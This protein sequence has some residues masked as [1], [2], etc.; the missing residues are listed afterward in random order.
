[1]L[2]GISMNPSGETVSSVTYNGVNLTHVGTQ[3]DGAALARVEIW[4]LVA[5]DTGTHDVVVNFTDLGHKGASVGVMTFTGVNQTTPTQAF[6]G[7]SGLS[8]SASTTVASATDDLVF[9]V[10]AV[11]KGTA[12]TPGA[13]QTEYWDIDV[14]AT[15]GAGTTEAG[16]ASVTTS[17]T[18]DLK[19]WSAAAVSI[20]ADDGTATILDQFNTAGSFAGND[21]T[22]NWTGDWQELGESNGASSGNV[23]VVA[24][25]AALLIGSTGVITGDGALREVDLSQASTATLT[26]DA[27]RSASRAATITLAVS[28]NGGTSWTNLQTWSFSS[29]TSTP[30]LQTFDISAYTS[31]NTQIRFLGAGEADSANFYADNIQIEYTAMPLN[32]APV[33]TVPGTQVT[34]QDTP[35]VFNTTNG[36]A[37]SIA[38]DDAG[39]S[40]VE[41]TLTATD[42]TLSLYGSGGLVKVGNEVTTNTDSSYVQANSK[43]A[44]DASGAYVVVWESIGQD[45]DMEGIF[46]QRYDADGIAIGSAWQVNTEFTDDQSEPAIAMDAAGNFVITWQSYAQDK[47]NT[48][49]VYAQRYNAAGV[50]QGGEIQVNTTTNGN[51]QYPDIAMDSAGNFVIV[52]DGQGSGDGNGIF[53]QR[54]DAAGNTVGGEILINTETADTQWRATVDM[55]AAGEFIVTWGSNL[56]DGDGWGIYAQRYNSDGTT[57]GGEFLV[58]A[59]TAG[60][61][62]DPVV[63]LKDDGEFVVGWSMDDA[64]SRGINARVFDA[65]ATA[66]T[67]DI[68]VN[69][70]TAGMQYPFDLA[71]SD[72]GG[73]VATWTGPVQDIFMQKFDWSGAKVGAEVLVNTTTSGTQT[74]STVA[75]NVNGDYVVL[76]KHDFSVPNN[77]IYAQHYYNPDLT[78]TNGDGNSDSAMTLSGTLADINTVLE[79]LTFNPDSGFNGTATVTITTDDQGNTGSG[80]AFSDSDM[81]MITVGNANAPVVNLD[82]N[83]S[84]GA[85]GNHFSTG[86]T[87]G[88]GTVL[89]A[90]SDA[91]LIDTDENVTGM[92]VTITNQ[93]NGTDEVLAA[94][95]SGTSILASYDSGTGV[96]TLSGADTAAKYQQ[97]LRTISYNNTATTVNATSR[98]ISFV[99]TDA[100]SNGNTA[101]TTLAVTLQNTAPTFGVGDGAITTAIGA[102]VDF[103]NSMIVQ[104]DGKILVAGY[105]HNGTDYDFA[106]T[107]YNAD[108]SLD[109]SFGGGDG[110]VTTAVGAGFDQAHAITLQPDGKILVTGS[111]HNGSNTDVALL[112][113][114]ADGTLD[115][116]FGGGDGIVTTNFGFGTDAG[117][118]VAVQADGKILVTGN[119]WDGS[120]QEIAL[121]RYNTDGTLDTSFSGDGKLTISF[122]VNND[123]GA[124]VTVQPDGQILV[125]GQTF[126]GTDNDLVLLRYNTD[127]TLDTSFSGD[128]IVITDVAS[129]GDAG[130]QAVLQPDGKIL[131]GGQTGPG[132]AGVDILLV[133]YN[134]D[135]SLDTTFGGG[136]GIAVLDIAAD[137][138][139]GRSIA[140]QPDGKILLAG[141]SDNGTDY[142][143]ALAR[144]NSDGTMDTGFGG[145]DGVVTTPVGSGDDI[146]YE[147]VL[148]PDG[149]ILVAGSSANGDADFAVV[150]YNPDGTLDTGFDTNILNGNPTFTVGGPAV[151]LDTDVQVS[152]A[153]LSASGDYNGSSLTLSR[154]GGANAED[155]FSATGNLAALTESGSL[156]LSGVTIGTVTTNSAGILVL[157]FNANATQARVNETLQSIA[158]E[159]SNGTPP[160]SVLVDWDFNDGNSGAQGAGG[161]LSGTGSTTVT[162]AGGAN[163]APTTDNVSTSGNEDATSIAITLTASDVDGTVDNYWLSTLPA[164]GT[165]YIDAGLTTA[166]ATA[167]D[168]AATAEALTLYFVPDT[169]WNGVTT[170]DFSARDNNGVLDAS[171]ATATLTVNPV[172]DAPTFFIG[173]GIVTTD[174]GSGEDIGNSVAVQADGKILVAGRSYN[175]TNFDFALTRYNADGTLDTSFNGDGRLTTDFGPGDDHSVS[176]SV[177]ADGKILAAGYSFN[178]SNYDFA[179]VRYNTDGTLDTGFSGDGKLTTA[180]GATGDIGYSHTVQA[181]GKILVSGYSVAGLDKDFALVRYNTDGTL[182][183]GF[184]GDGKLT[185]DFGSNEDIGYSVTLQADGK[186]LVAGASQNGAF[187]RLCTGTLQHR[188]LAGHQ[189]QR[190]RHAHHRHRGERRCWLQCHCPARRQDPGG[191]LQPQRG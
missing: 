163:S 107:R 76:W 156:V 23:R 118:S 153:E 20:Q 16:A 144:F 186:I 43:A 61:Q 113:Y 170:F 120:R 62:W 77:G 78:F 58:N 135:G 169:N 168:Y 49:G 39:A 38:D 109:T 116:S 190:R 129:G 19:K 189:L 125:T 67:G 97:V 8:T 181:D 51:Q 69:T 71:L 87:E 112:R 85:G 100:I 9:G 28:D 187:Q 46:A 1:M 93:L 33:N 142:D 11:E 182:D 68:A 3:E 143:F 178:G 82:A 70:T 105:S 54:F 74:Q 24:S 101:T 139:A 73:F 36:N 89:I 12:V 148:Q 4:S 80:G 122:G 180:I 146:G 138:D 31:A 26:F 127:G 88:G 14:N 176:V 15:N 155:V 30:A 108:S 123:F 174:F 10:V 164:N 134:S 132:G 175:G 185:T 96:L 149:Q 177:Q 117:K 99:P 84:S 106:L 157:T 131:I 55:N 150:R 179:L 128:G 104:S 41:V 17:W 47:N 124:R 92:T 133:R 130:Y 171:P 152:D 98:V 151:V 48:F 64:D 141:M 111:S 75:S 81:I 103:G 110:I 65:S 172:N 90:D 35:V 161:S 102:G 115:T 72:D 66:L 57:N 94:D 95:T 42:G 145:G 165:L 56:Q 173:D 137:Y 59:I 7:D 183:T 184:S 53:G 121:L 126:N 27:W 86:W 21:G 119:A 91:T 79:G 22:Q 34:P 44:M 60:A 45:G 37:V 29:L 63:A 159:N 40:P 160:A 52:W 167:T 13:G 158:Y 140:L 5:P 188:R 162:I 114:N 25:P 6:S 191:R 154:N 18:N 147:V 136:D 2:V 166:A 32:D 50:A 83:D